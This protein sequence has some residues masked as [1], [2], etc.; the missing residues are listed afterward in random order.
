MG[1]ILVQ[2]G[3]L[4]RAKKH[5]PLV[6]VI[7]VDLYPTLHL[8]HILLMLYVGQKSLEYSQA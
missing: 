6:A 8:G 7:K 2:H 1:D 5:A 3:K 4:A